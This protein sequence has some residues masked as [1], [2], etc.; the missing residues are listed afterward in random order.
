M[1]VKNSMCRN[2]PAYTFFFLHSQVQ[3]RRLFQQLQRLSHN[4]KA[5]ALLEQGYKNHEPGVAYLN[6][7]QYDPLRSDPRFNEFV[8]RIRLPESGPQ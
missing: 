5:L 6:V 7:P 4:E 2:L 3:S 1:A 8:R